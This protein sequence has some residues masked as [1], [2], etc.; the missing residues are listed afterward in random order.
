MALP[1]RLQQPEQP[2]AE[3][4]ADDPAGDQHAAHL[5][6]HPVAAEIGEHAGNARPRHRAR[7]AGGGDGGRDAID[8]QQRRGEEPAADP[9]HA[10]EQ[11]HPRAERDD[12]ER[13][14]RQ[15]GDRQVKVHPASGKRFA[16]RAEDA[17][18]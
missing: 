4:R 6:V 2:R 8:D 12:D 7:G 16:C 1:P 15:V 5:H 10:G 14:H 3:Q 9:E 18:S 11:P 17:G 13:V